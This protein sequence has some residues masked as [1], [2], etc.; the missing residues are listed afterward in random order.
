MAICYLS[1]GSNLGDRRRHI[2]AAVQKINALAGTRIIKM[3]R[4]IRTKAVGGPLLQGDFL[5]A[6]LKIQTCFSPFALLKKLKAIEKKIGRVKTVRWGPRV[7]DLDI[8][9][10]DAR[11]ITAAQLTI[12]HPRMFERP[13]VLKPLLEVI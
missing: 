5:N 9:L 3:S 7:I 2:V 1:I 6:A 11:V 13:F 8:L 10:Y 4:P 12:P